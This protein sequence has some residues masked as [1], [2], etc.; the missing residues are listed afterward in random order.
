MNFCVKW[1]CLFIWKTIEKNLQVASASLSS[2]FAGTVDLLRLEAL[3]L[4]RMRHED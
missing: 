2:Y 1:S 3:F 4:N